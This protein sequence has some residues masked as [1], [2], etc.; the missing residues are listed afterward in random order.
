MRKLP[1]LSHKH[2]ICI[3]CEGLEEFQYVER[4]R[5]LGVWSSEYDF[6]MINAKGESNVF[7][8]FQDVYSKDSYE[9]IIIFCDTDKEP[10]KQYKLLKQKLNGF[11]DKEEVDQKIVLWANPCSMQIILSH[12]EKVCLTTQA[13]KTNAPLIEKLTGVQNYNGHENQIIQVCSKIFRRSYPE[14]KDR[15]RETEYDDEK[16][17]TSNAVLFMENF[18]KD[19]PKWIR[20][21]NQYLEE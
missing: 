14:M 17:G 3:V 11:F 4:L 6:T 21:I 5:E 1:I 9:L 18:E 2:K 20:Q 10:Y 15:L 13:K 16:S 8:R 12:F 19:D 7:A